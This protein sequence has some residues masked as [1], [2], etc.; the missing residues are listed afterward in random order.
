MLFLLNIEVLR[1]KNQKDFNVRKIKT[2]N[3]EGVFFRKMTFLC[4]KMPLSQ[5][6]EGV[7]YTTGSWPSY[8]FPPFYNECD[9]NP[10]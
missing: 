10:I 9:K 8:F 5:K 1:Q 7:K 2:N 3:Q 4:L 6:W